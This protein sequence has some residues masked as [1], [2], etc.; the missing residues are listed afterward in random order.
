MMRPRLTPEDFALE[1][2]V[3]LEEIDRSEDVTTSQ[4]NRRL[5]QTYFAG[6]P[7]G[8]GVLGSSESITGLAVEQMREYAR[9]RYAANNLMLVLAGNFEWDQVVELAEQHAGAWDRGE[10]GREAGSFAP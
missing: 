5:M 2:N 7:L 9:R 8:H 10:A 3:I 1:R 4:E 6:H